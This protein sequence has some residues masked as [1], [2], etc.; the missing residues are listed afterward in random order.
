[1]LD[2][3]FEKYIEEAKKLNTK[4][5]YDEIQDE[6]VQEAVIQL[7]HDGYNPVV[8]WKK[9]EL[10]NIFWE[11]LSEIERFIMPESEEKSVN[12][13][14]KLLSEKK[15]DGLISGC[16]NTT[17]DTLRA[18]IRNV[19]VFRDIKRI[20][21]FFIMNTSRGIKIFSDSAVQPNPNAEQ[22]AEI[23]YLSGKNAE[24]F[25]LKPKIALLSFSTR[26]SANHP[27]VTKVQ[28][29]TQI[30]KARIKK[31]KLN[32]KVEGEVQLDAAIS[33]RVAIKKIKPAG[34]VMGEANVIV[35]PDLN[36]GNIWY[37]LV[38]YFWSAQAIGPILQGLKKPGNDLSRWCSVEDIY[39]LHAIT[40]LQASKQ[41]N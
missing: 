19:G 38:Q 12:Y 24:M 13:A 34:E 37:K 27:M 28:E 2:N 10:E 26:G 3:F 29:A 1:M 14:S 31:E 36:S 9:E 33:R 11:H 25:G 22:L 6:R 41:N 4:I 20:S 5:I 8:T 15:V 18:L 21:G 23:A 32:Y 35:F 16:L 30:L 17:A 39:T 40:A 7:Q